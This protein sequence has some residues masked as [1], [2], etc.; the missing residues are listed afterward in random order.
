MARYGFP[1]L[2]SAGTD[3]QADE[4]SPSRSLAGGNSDTLVHQHQEHQQQ[5]HESPGQLAEHQLFAASPVL[6]VLNMTTP[7][8]ESNHADTS[9]THCDA[10]IVCSPDYIL[11]IATAV[12]V[13]LAAV[14]TVGNILTVLAILNSRLRQNINSI[15]ICN[16]SVADAVYCGL[17]L[18]L[19]ALAFHHKAWILSGLVCELHAALR[20]WLIGI[21]MMLLSFI[22]LYRFLHV[23]R[24]QSYT[25]YSQTPWFVAAC[26]LCW[27]LPFI[28]SLTPLVHLW[29]EFAFQDRILQC[30]FGPDSSKSHKITTITAGYLVPCVFICVCYARIGCVVFRSRHR[31]VKSGSVYRRQRAR[32]DSFRLTGMMVLIF[33][34]FLL[35]TTPYFVVNSL[36][37]KLLRPVAHIIT[38]V[39]AWIMYGTHPLIYTVMDKKFQAA[40]RRLLACI[41]A[42]KHIPPETSLQEARQTSQ[43]V[44]REPGEKVKASVRASESL[45]SP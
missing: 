33:V 27:V 44:K 12:T 41:I 39:L 22:A 29:G 23:V 16:L 7:G 25:Y 28:F 43:L 20:I 37:P 42:S 13:C 35:G 21:N 18:P 34:G 26:I 3:S 10:G 1:S 38:P 15:L 36:D 32:R 40:Y 2:T 4:V 8:M 5:A 17:V 31:A 14:G 19:Q 45:E 11:Q 24:P 6:S 30:T 9:A